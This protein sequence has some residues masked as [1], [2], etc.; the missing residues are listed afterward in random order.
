MNQTLKPVDLPAKP[1]LAGRGPT[2][3]AE[4]TSYKWVGIGNGQ[5]RT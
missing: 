2:G 3:M 4:L 5:V 1:M